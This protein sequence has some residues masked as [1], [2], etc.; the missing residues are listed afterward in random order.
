MLRTG[1]RRSSRYIKDDDYSRVDLVNDNHSITVIMLAS[2][3]RSIAISNNALYSLSLSLSYS[4]R[5]FTKN[6]EKYLKYTPDTLEDCLK[7]FFDG[8]AP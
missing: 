4:R 2:M 5:N 7:S 3:V 1:T 6:P 8:G